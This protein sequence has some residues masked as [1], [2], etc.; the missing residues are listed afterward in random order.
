M[1]LLVV[2]LV[3][4][5]IY[6]RPTQ[7]DPEIIQITG[8]VGNPLN[9]TI[10]DL[11]AYPSVTMKV[12]VTSSGHSSGNGDYNYTG[13]L[14][15]DLLSQAQVF[16]NASTVFIQALDGYG[17]TITMQEA[18]TQTTFIAYAKDG[19]ALSS[20]KDG[21]EGPARLIINSDQYAQRWVRGVTA[22]IVS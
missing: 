13:V 14:L 22:L 2:A 18:T 21:G 3:P 20:L 19:T 8:Q 5:Y 16:S 12:T 11:E 17:T 10:N 6:T 9:I 15:Q 1:I 4:L 7:S